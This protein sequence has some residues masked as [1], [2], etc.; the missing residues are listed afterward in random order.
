M[1]VT[2]RAQLHPEIVFSLG[3]VKNFNFGGFFLLEE[4]VGEKSSVPPQEESS[5]KVNLHGSVNALA[6]KCPNTPPNGQYRSV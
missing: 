2:N 6:Q 3:E 1:S 4:F 5:L